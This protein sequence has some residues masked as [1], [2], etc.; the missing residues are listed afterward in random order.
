VK[1]A[2]VSRVSE[3]QIDRL[4]KSLDGL[5]NRLEEIERRRRDDRAL[6]EIA[7]PACVV[8]GAL[9]VLTT[10]TWR[11]VDDSNDMAD[12]AISLWGLTQEGWQATATLALVLALAIGTVAAFVGNSGRVAHIVLVVVAVGAL[13]AIAF[14]IGQLQPIGFYDPDEAKVGSGRW[15]AALACVTLAVING[16]RASERIPPKR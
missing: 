13:F 16:V 9:A 11:S 4:Q 5:R 8:A 3:E 1:L 14:L 6:L 12:R 7:L 10:S 2:I 15:L